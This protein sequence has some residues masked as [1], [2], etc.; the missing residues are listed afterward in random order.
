MLRAKV[1]AIEATKYCL[2]YVQQILKGSPVTDSEAGRKLAVRVTEGRAILQDLC[3]L[4]LTESSQSIV[5]LEL[6][7]IRSLFQSIRWYE[8]Y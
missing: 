1:V 4:L 3:V 7:T 6:Q 8:T 5:G 2:A